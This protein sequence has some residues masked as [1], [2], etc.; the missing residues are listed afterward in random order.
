MT[1]RL[2]L[3]ISNIIST[4]KMSS[5]ADRKKSLTAVTSGGAQE[6]GD[7][8]ALRESR[9]V[10]SVRFVYRGNYGDDKDG[11]HMGGNGGKDDYGG[12]Y[13]G[14]DYSN[15]DGN[16][17]YDNDDNG[18]CGGNDD[19]DGNNDVDD[20]GQVMIIVMMLIMVVMMMVVIIW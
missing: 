14:N 20:D 17:E 6:D 15:N 16:D 10:G 4:G 12:Y 2:I 13:D 19:D 5:K 1:P 3:P 18:D 9:E 8:V 11:Y 7:F